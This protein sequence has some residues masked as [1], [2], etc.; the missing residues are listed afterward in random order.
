MQSNFGNRIGMVKMFEN[1]NPNTYLD[2]I[3]QLETSTA[4]DEYKYNIL[5][6]AMFE[7]AVG[8]DCVIFQNDVYM[9]IIIQSLPML[10]DNIRE[11]LS[12]NDNMDEIK[13]ML[14]QKP[15][16][17]ST[18]HDQNYASFI[19][20]RLCMNYFNVKDHLAT[21]MTYQVF[22]DLKDTNRDV[23]ESLCKCID[24]LLI[25]LLIYEYERNSGID[26]IT[27]KS[28]DEGKSKLRIFYP[29]FFKGKC[30]VFI[31]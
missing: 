10:H 2:I 7:L 16:S 8:R 1:I 20:K 11:Y 19:N 30:T 9:E 18:D 31:L 5:I 23:Y 6:D 26:F 12:S 28:V 22:L 25:G 17:I 14:N 13:N 29:D 27:S 4:T 15:L 21:F 24:M 3:R